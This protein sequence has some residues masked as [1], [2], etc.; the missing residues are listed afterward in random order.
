MLI[1]T[2]IILSTVLHDEIR[3]ILVQPAFAKTKVGGFMLTPFPAIGVL[4]FCLY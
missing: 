1:G 3:S 4:L 2:E